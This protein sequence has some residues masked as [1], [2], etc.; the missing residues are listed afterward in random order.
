MHGTYIKTSRMEVYFHA[1]FSLELHTAAGY[2]PRPLDL[3]SKLKVYVRALTNISRNKPNK[4]TNI[5][6]VFCTQ[7]LS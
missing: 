3:L 2:M 6:I 7:N 5:K 1:F 4:C